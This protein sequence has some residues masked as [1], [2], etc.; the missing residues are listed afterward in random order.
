MNKEIMIFI[1]DAKYYAEQ[2]SIVIVGIEAE[3]KKPITQQI[4]VRDFLNGTGLF[5]SG[6][7]DSIVQNT[8]RCKLLA[9]NLKSR[10]DPFKLVFTG[11]QTEEQLKEWFETE[12]AKEDNA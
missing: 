10:Q 11:E 8:D 9:N 6:E 12:A 2:K 7:V 4:T 3:S 1:Q 5:L